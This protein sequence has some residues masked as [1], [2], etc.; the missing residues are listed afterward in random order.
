M[1]AMKDRGFYASESQYE[2]QLKVW[3]IRKNW[4]RG[5]RSQTTHFF[6]IMNGMREII[7]LR[8]DSVAQLEEMLALYSQF[9]PG[10][11]LESIVSEDIPDLA[12]WLT[13]Q[14]VFVECIE[15][16][17]KERNSPIVSWE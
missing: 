16:R 13:E 8:I 12:R 7:A 10:T 1:G 4:K 9:R 15:N 17:L 5:D 6:E 11:D 2:R 3:G 14:S